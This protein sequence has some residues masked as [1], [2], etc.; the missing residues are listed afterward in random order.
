MKELAKLCNVSVSTVSKA[1][2]NTEDISSD[3]KKLIFETAKK[4]GCY[5]KFYKHK[6]PKRIIAII[7]P[8]IA[9]NYYSI[10]IEELQRLIESDNGICVISSYNFCSEKKY[11]LIEYYSSYITVDGIIVIGSVENLKKGCDVPIVSLFS[12]KCNFVDSVSTDIEFAINEAVETL[13]SYG[14]KKIAFIGEPLTES[15]ALYFKNSTKNKCNNEFII[16]Q[17]DQRFEKAGVDGV[18]HLLS[19]SQDFTAIICAYDNIAFGAIK[20]LKTRGFKVPEDISVIGIDN[21]CLSEFTETSLTSIDTKPS[22]I[23][24]LAWDL[25]CKKFKNKYFRINQSIVVKPQLII[26]ESIAN[27]RK[28]SSD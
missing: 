10:F 26:R 9:S 23:C 19:K 12:D 1:F 14:H 28:R 21:I 8:E 22:D 18:R 15:K 27:L 25:L 4:E 7:C 24:T 13:I 6:Y 20:E 2:S 16:I 11:E 17:S 5:G 3:T